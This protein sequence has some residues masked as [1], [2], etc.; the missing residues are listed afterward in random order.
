MSVLNLSRRPLFGT[1]I[2]Q[3]PLTLL[4]VVFVVSRVVYWLLGVRFLFQA[5]QFW[6]FINSDILQAHFWE[7]LWYLH[8]QPPLLNFILGL[9]YQG[10]GGYAGAAGAMNV[11]FI[12]L[13][14]L[15]VISLYQLLLALD[16]PIWLAFSATLLYTISPIAILYEN[17]FMTTYPIA[18]LMPFTF[19]RFARFIRTGSARDGL[20]LALGLTAMAWIR[21]SIHLVWV[22][23]VVVL[24]LYYAPARRSKYVVLLA[25]LLVGLLYV[26]NLALFGSPFTSSWFSMSAYNLAVRYFPPEDYERMIA[27]GELLVP[28]GRQPFQVP[29]R[30]LGSYTPRF[31]NVALFESEVV[32]G[33]INYHHYAYIDFS[34]NFMHDVMVMLRH[35]PQC[36]LRSWVEA[37]RVYLLSASEHGL[38]GS[39]NLE[40]VAPAR[41]FLNNVI[42]GRFITRSLFGFNELGNTYPVI[43]LGVPLVLVAGL[44]YSI[45]ALLKK[46]PLA[47]VLFAMALSSVFFAATYTLFEIDENQRFRFETDTLVFA[48]TIFLLWRLYQYL[49]ERRAGR[50]ANPPLVSA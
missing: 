29:I 23:F 15:L 10:F 35:C 26:K 3:H 42:Y 32:D 1:G 8:T 6:Q 46:Q 44:V 41:W 38:L 12:G 18:S 49:Q 24:A 43:L 34:S 21:S 16:L 7:S 31:E 33:Q 27:S 20:L 4:M 11:L 9:A 37:S 14:I 50:A 13:G 48:M 28:A 17:Y 5:D 45:R 40:A 22:A 47:P 19:W 39:G 2:L 25:V 36:Y 30:D